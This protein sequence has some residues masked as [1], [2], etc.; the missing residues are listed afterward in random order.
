MS[1]FASPEVRDAL[2][3]LRGSWVPMHLALARSV[4]L[5]CNTLP[6]MLLA[7]VILQ[8]WQEQQ[9]ELWRNG[10]EFSTRV[11]LSARRIGREL[12]QPALERFPEPEEGWASKDAQKAWEK[13]I[14]KVDSNYRRTVKR[15]LDQLERLGLIENTEERADRGVRIYDVRPM[16]DLLADDVRP[17]DVEGA[18]GT[19]HVAPEGAASTPSMG[20][21]GT[22]HRVPPAP[23][24]RVPRAPPSERESSAVPAEQSSIEQRAAGAAAASA[25]ASATP[26]AGWDP[27]ECAAPPPRNGRTFGELLERGAPRRTTASDVKRRLDEARRAGDQDA[28]ALYADQLA[29][30]RRA[31]PDLVEAGAGT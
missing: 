7:T 8:V 3:G 4:R 2:M 16:L 11:P 12:W 29:A 17:S 6:Q 1:R 31:A 25:G 5:R 20:A 27:P 24:P 9:Q 28:A 14:D 21:K 13:E 15:L 22:P 30:M 19:P 18:K 26:A 23:R 10:S